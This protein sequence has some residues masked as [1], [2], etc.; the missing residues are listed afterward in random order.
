MLGLAAMVIEEG[1]AEVNERGG[2]VK[3]V[4]QLRVEE[5]AGCHG[6]WKT[7]FALRMYAQ[8][9]MTFKGGMVSMLGRTEQKWDLKMFF[10]G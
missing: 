4:T 10:D 1:E 2:G 9:L 6:I 5:C 8:L 3:C 7:Y